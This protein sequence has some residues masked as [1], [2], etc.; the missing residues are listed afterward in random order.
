MY[1]LLLFA[2]GDAQWTK[3]EEAK[4]NDL[5]LTYINSHDE[6]HCIR[7]VQQANDSKTT[8][9][10]YSKQYN[11]DNRERRSR[12]QKLQR[13]F[14]DSTEEHPETPALDLAPSPKYVILSSAPKEKAVFYILITELK[15][16][17][18]LLLC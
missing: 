2:D 1:F 18:L 8:K 5:Y 14:K 11:P 16:T 7:T 3:Q 13:Q 17:S 6:L 4:K 15:L 10:D 12:S 9:E